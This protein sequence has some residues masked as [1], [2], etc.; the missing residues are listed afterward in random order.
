MSL[1]LKYD[2]SIPW[3][4]KLAG[5]I[6]ETWTRRLSVCFC[7]CSCLLVSVSHGM[8]ARTHCVAGVVSYYYCGLRSVSLWLCVCG[9]VSACLHIC[10]CVCVCVTVYERE[11]EREREKEREREA[12]R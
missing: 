7:F 10:V 1:V 8:L 5:F 12:D 9:N 4:G 3:D 11:R 6:D 2:G